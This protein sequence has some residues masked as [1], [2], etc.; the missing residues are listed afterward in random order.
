[1]ESPLK[2]GTVYS[3]LNKSSCPTS[4]TTPN[5]SCFCIS[6]LGAVKPN[7][8]DRELEVILDLSLSIV[9]LIQSFAAIHARHSSFPIFAVMALLQPFIPFT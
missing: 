7:S 5:S 8:Q 1:M 9:L 4:L 2:S 3:K 6:N